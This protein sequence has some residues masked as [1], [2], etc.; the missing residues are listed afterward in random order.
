[1]AKQAHRMNDTSERERE[2]ERAEQRKHGCPNTLVQWYKVSSDENCGSGLC[3]FCQSKHQ[4]T[5]DGRRAIQWRRC[6][7]LSEKSRV[8][9]ITFV[10]NHWNQFPS[11][12]KSIVFRI[13][14]CVTDS[15]SDDDNRYAYLKTRHSVQWKDHYHGYSM[16]SF[17]TILDFYLLIYSFSRQR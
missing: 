7:C 9:S 15:I 17:H 14:T 2:R 10:N 12:L 6:F 5:T 1:M 3:N 4:N 16:R 11:T 13:R 8:K